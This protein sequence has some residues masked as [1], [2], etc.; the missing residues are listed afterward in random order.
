MSATEK[1]ET[2]EVR[3][4]V[5]QRYAEIAR[6]GGIKS[7]VGCCGPQP[8]QI[9]E[10]IG[11]SA[12]D[13]EVVPE[14]ANLGL[15]CGA[16]LAAAA[17]KEGETVLD[18]GSGAGFDAFLAARAVGS[19]GRVIG[20]DMTDEMLAKARANA[21]SAGV[22]NVEFRK[23]YI[24]ALPIEDAS[25]DVVLSNCV[26]N[27]VPDKAAVYREVARVLRAGGR[28]IISDIALNEPLPD[29]IASDV[30]ALTGCIAGAAL[31]E[32]YLATIATAGLTEIEI[33]G[34]KGFGTLALTMVSE[35][36]LQHANNLGIDVER[37]AETVRS[38][39]I[40]AVKPRSA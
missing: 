10:R 37:V 29:A 15:G 20:V 5:R 27:L 22:S 11:Y 12:Q 25:V 4:L 30:A 6:D 31:R 35:A 23:G 14:G 16:P 26:I 38:L 13:T 40:R 21:Q 33:L 1:V 34:D 24:E 18:L 7:E 9:A 28:M 17:L 19:T 3:E 32:Q 39:T 36:M 8:A 2:D